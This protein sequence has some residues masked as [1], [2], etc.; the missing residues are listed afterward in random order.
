MKSFSVLDVYS[1]LSGIW[2]DSNKS[3]LYSQAVQISFVCPMNFKRFPLDKQRCQFR[4]GS[5]SYGVAQ[6]I[7]ITKEFG[8]SS[9]S[10]NVNKNSPPLDY[11]LSMEALKEN[12]IDYGSLGNFSVAGFEIILSRHSSSYLVTYYLPAGVLVLISW[13]SF[14]I[15]YDMVAA[16]M[17]LL[18]ILFLALLNIINTIKPELPKAEGLTAIE[19]WLLVCMLFLFGALIEYAVLLFK[20][21]QVKK[22][23]PSEAKKANSIQQL[24]E[25]CSRIDQY[26]LISF[27]IIFFMFNLIYWPA[28]TL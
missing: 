5:Y 2:I 25:Q 26:V 19:V 28:Y 10:K 23:N 16:R 18:V 12:V 6:M 22:K 11:D 3:V 1:K 21:L 7:F 8:Y 27:P 24:A 20:N 13:V 9:Y 4:V 15:P 17:T 14:M